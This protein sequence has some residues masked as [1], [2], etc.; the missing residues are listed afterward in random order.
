M[1]KV[2]RSA[3]LQLEMITSLNDELRNVHE[4]GKKVVY[5]FVPGNLSELIL[6]LDMLPVYP[7]I[8]AIQSGLRKKSGKFIREAESFGYPEDVCSYIKCD[9]GMMLKGNKGP[10]FGKI[11]NPDLLLLSYTSGVMLMKWFEILKRLYPDVPIVM[12]HTPYL[13][14]GTVTK[15]MTQYVV[16]QLKDIVIPVM[17]K[18]SGNRLDVSLLSEILRNSLKAE[19]IMVDIFNLAKSKPSP[20]D[21]FFAGVSFIGP[22]NNGFRGTEKAVDYYTLLYDELLTR[23][24]NNEGA[25]IPLGGIVEEKYRLV[26]EGPPNWTSFNEFWKLFYDNCAVTVSASYARI[27][28]LFDSGFRHDPAEPLE[29]IATYCMNC[30]T[31]YSLPERTELLKGFLR[32]YSADGLIVNSIK[33]AKSFSVGQLLMMRKIEQELEI[34]VCFIETDFVDERYFTYANI[35]NRLDSFFQLLEQRREFEER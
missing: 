16:K 2:I 14:N 5:T 32:D 31:N 25:E 10:V 21:A 35:K 19:D 11:P 6:A 30:Y 15:E 24:R 28:G 8:N 23:N 17:E 27:G 1:S 3:D 20:Y 33:S 13:E 22:L 34:P 26:I 12:L 18:V 29:S 4:T 7:E 9:I